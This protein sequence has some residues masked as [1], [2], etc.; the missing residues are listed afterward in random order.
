MLSTLSS[1]DGAKPGAR[2]QSAPGASGPR[3]PRLGGETILVADDDAGVRYAL[4][5]ALRRFGFRVI[6]AASGNDAVALCQ[7]EL[8]PVDMVLADVVMPSLTTDELQAGLAAARPEAALMFMSGY[9]HDEGVRRR[10]IHGPV[11]FMAKPF[12]VPELVERV[13]QLLRGTRT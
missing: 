6:E 9:I 3:R 8:G 11:P 1:T 10:V 2:T 12:T 4:A 13:R 7:S 5:S